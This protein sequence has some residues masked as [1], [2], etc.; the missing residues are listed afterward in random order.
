MKPSQEAIE[1]NEAHRLL[2]LCIGTPYEAA[3]RRRLR[4][5]VA[6]VAYEQ[7]LRHHDN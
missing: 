3:A 4:N 2:K 6:R 5:I 7:T 1:I